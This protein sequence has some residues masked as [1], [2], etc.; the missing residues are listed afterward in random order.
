MPAGRVQSVCRKKTARQVIILMAPL[1]LL[2]RRPVIRRYPLE[3]QGPQA[4]PLA[5]R[6]KPSRRAGVRVCVRACVRAYVCVVTSGY[7][8]PD[9]KVS[10]IGSRGHQSVIPPKPITCPIATRCHHNLQK[11]SKPLQQYKV[12]WHACV[13][14]QGRGMYNYGLLTR[15]RQQSKTVVPGSHWHSNAVQLKQPCAHSNCIP[16]LRLPSYIMISTMCTAV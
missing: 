6:A 3:Q 14:V 12:S 8:K 16:K 10:T 1:L 7:V 9:L 13:H 15:M 2:N 11:I 5:S 4:A